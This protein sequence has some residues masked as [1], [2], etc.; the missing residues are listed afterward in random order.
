MGSGHLVRLITDRHD[1]ARD[2]LAAETLKRVLARN[3]RAE[4][5]QHPCEVDNESKRL[6]RRPFFFGHPG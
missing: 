6:A 1:T 3:G 4:F 2:A 5:L